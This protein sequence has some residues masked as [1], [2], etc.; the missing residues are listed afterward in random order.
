MDATLFTDS[1]CTLCLLL[2]SIV[3]VVVVGQDYHP[4]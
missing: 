4:G 3:V 2:S 1:K